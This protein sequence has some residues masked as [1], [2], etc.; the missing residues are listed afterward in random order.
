MTPGPLAEAAA[1]PI[2]RTARR[3]KRVLVNGRLQCPHWDKEP[4]LLL[5][6]LSICPPGLSPLVCKSDPDRCPNGVRH[7]RFTTRG[8][9][10]G[11]ETRIVLAYLGAC[12]LSLI[13]VGLGLKMPPRSQGQ[14]VGSAPRKVP[15]LELQSSSL[16]S[17]MHFL[18]VRYVRNPR[19]RTLCQTPAAAS[20]QERS[21]AS[22]CEKT[23]R[24]VIQA[25]RYPRWSQPSKARRHGPQ[26]R[27]PHPL[28][29]SESARAHASSP[30]P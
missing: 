16:G 14:R 8:E 27:R 1:T 11:C 3:P 15:T 12:Q 7:V 19:G 26:I 29:V 10:P 25:H 22:R 4:R 2:P 13:E 21:E 30:R 18:N 6:L 5:R 9:R 17:L 24:F 23:P 28:Q 20:K